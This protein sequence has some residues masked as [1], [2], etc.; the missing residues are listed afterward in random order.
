MVWDD[1]KPQIND[2][3]AEFPSLMTGNAIAFRQG[4]EKYS[5]WTDSSGL[6]A[7]IPRLSA[8][9]LGPGAARAYYGNESSL[10]T[11]ASV[12]KPLEG[13]FFVALDTGRLYAF[14]PSA[15]TAQLGGVNHIVWQPSAATIP[16]NT[17][18]LVQQGSVNAIVPGAL[19]LQPVTFPSAYSVAPTVQATILSLGTTDILMAFVTSITT[20]GCSIGCHQLMSASAASHTAYWRSHGTAAL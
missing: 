1:R 14:S 4:V 17:R 11:A 15:A 5:F 8:A 18:V 10:S 19:G 9:S 12:N 2:P 13:R 7:G 20:V 16:S 6:S 3:L